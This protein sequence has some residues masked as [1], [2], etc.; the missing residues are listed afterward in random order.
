MEADMLSS[1]NPLL[2][3]ELL[4]EELDKAL[5]KLKLI[6]YKMKS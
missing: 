4:P 1:E 5:R 6:K 3:G 2:N